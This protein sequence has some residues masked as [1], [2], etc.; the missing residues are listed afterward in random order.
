MTAGSAALVWL[1]PLLAR[2]A[3][4]VWSCRAQGVAGVGWRPNSTCSLKL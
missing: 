4:V 1:L 2:D 3:L